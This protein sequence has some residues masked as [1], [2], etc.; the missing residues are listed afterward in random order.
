MV[1]LYG[2]RP[3][4]TA[5]TGGF[6]PRRA[7]TQKMMQVAAVGGH[8]RHMACWMQIQAIPPRRWW[9]HLHTSLYI[10]HS[11]LEPDFSTKMEMAYTNRT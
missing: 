4:L 8:G 5:K 3:R 6:R 9:S 2:C 10:N 11:G 1:L 7:D